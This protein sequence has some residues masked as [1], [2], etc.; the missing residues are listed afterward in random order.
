MI[1]NLNCHIQKFLFHFD[2]TWISSCQWQ[3]KSFCWKNRGSSRKT[4][5]VYAYVFEACR[6]N[7]E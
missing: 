1:S 4:E 5:F 7:Y 3:S 2:L 6:E